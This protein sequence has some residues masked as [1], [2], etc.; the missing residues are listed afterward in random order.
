MILFFSEEQWAVQDSLKWYKNW[1]F[2]WKYG[3]LYLRIWIQIQIL[4]ERLDQD[5]GP[6]K[7]NMDPQPWFKENMIIGFLVI[8]SACM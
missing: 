1:I 7:T 4:W 6:F 8:L 5:P 2:C 3:I